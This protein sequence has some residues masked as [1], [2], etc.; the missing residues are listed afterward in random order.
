M[1]E[2]FIGLLVIVGL[3][4]IGFLMTGI[5]LAQYEFWAPKYQNAQR[6]VY[7]ETKSYRDGNRRDFERL[8]VSYMS[9][10]D[11]A[12][13][14]AILSVAKSEADGVDPAIVP[15]NLKDLLCNQ[16]KDCM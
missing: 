8:Y 1:K 10:Q 3:F 2:L 13:K 4:A 7:E 6:K 14:E 16:L 15:Q 9:Q 5:D 12:S 11:P